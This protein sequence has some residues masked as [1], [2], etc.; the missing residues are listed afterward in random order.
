MLD[1]GI[2]GWGAGAFR[3]VAGVRGLVVRRDEMFREVFIRRDR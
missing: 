3:E 1:V 2:V